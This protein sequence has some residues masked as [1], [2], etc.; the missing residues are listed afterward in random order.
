[1]KSLISNNS[2]R[3]QQLL[4]KLCET[5]HFNAIYIMEVFTKYGNF[6]AKTDIEA[7]GGEVYVH[8]HPGGQ[9]VLILSKGD[10]LDDHSD[11]GSL[12]GHHHCHYL[13]SH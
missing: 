6:L 11:N 5:I 7:R 13:Q 9:E 12:Q 8:P 3:A 1:M 4:L 10:K 2:K